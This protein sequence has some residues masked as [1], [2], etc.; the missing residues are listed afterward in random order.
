MKDDQLLDNDGYEFKLYDNPNF[1]FDLPSII[2]GRGV[3]SEKELTELNVLMLS[4]QLN[5]DPNTILFNQVLDGL[6]TNMT[7]KQTSL[8][9][10]QK[11]CAKKQFQRELTF[12]LK[13]DQCSLTYNF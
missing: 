2:K 1:K 10:K 9:V 5:T 4:K 13:P 6:I 11:S 7:D 12:Q 3:K 8:F